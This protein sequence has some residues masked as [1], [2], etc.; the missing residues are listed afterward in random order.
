MQ[1][2]DFVDKIYHQVVEKDLN[3]FDC[4]FPLRVFRGRPKCNLCEERRNLLY[5]S[6]NYK[7]CVWCNINI[8][9][10]RI[11]RVFRTYIRN[12][13]LRRLDFL[14][15]ILISNYKREMNNGIQINEENLKECIC[16]NE[17]KQILDRNNCCFGCKFNIMAY[18][19]QHMYR[20]K[21]QKTNPERSNIM[22]RIRPYERESLMNMDM[23]NMK[24]VE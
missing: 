17:M 6:D 18:R 3:N 24:L 11:Q 20:M 5:I 7:Y 1:R 23:N 9:A 19:I 16:C 14:D 2:Q 8:M 22:E 13:N 10:F 4:K 21:I 15:D 12:K